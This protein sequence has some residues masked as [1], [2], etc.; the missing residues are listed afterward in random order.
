MNSSFLFTFFMIFLYASGMSSTWSPFQATEH[1]FSTVICKIFHAFEH[2]CLS[3]N[4]SQFYW[5][6]FGDKKIRP[7]HSI[8]NLVKNIDLYSDFTIFNYLPLFPNIFKHLCQVL[9]YCQVLRLYFHGTMCHNPKVL[10][11]S[12][13][14]ELRCIYITDEFV[15]SCVSLY[16]SLHWNLFAVLLRRHLVL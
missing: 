11:M 5:I 8:Q 12:F 3:L 10:F 6:L 13:S 4:L 2:Y 9:V 7:A 15:P 1:V 16:T 14:D